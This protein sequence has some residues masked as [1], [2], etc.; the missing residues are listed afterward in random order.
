M[1][2]AALLSGLSAANH[3]DR[4]RA[5]QDVRAVIARTGGQ[6]RFRAQE[7]IFVLLAGLLK[8]ANWNLR[9]DAIGLFGELR[10]PPE[11]QRHLIPALEPLI[12]N[13]ADAK[14]S[15]RRATGVTIDV[16]ERRKK[17]K[18]EKRRRKKL[19]APSPQERDGGRKKKIW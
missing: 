1:D 17:N 4:A 9:L 11:G 5:L 8:D 12:G 3:P 15:I 7:R 2:E 19:L 14:V 16:R 18:K 13:F 6:P 10:L